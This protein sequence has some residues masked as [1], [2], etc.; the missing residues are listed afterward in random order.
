MISD[1]ASFF[2]DTNRHV[3]FVFKRPLYFTPR[4]PIPLLSSRTATSILLLV[5]I[6][7]VHNMVGCVAFFLHYYSDGVRRPKLPWYLLWV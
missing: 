1:N 7:S 6:F 2:R 5:L 3:S 4:Y